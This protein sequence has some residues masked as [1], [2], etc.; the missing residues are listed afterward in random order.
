M[1][2]KVW[3][4]IPGSGTVLGQSP[5]AS[6]HFIGLEIAGLHPKVWNIFETGSQDL[7]GLEGVG[8]HPRV[9]NSFRTQSQHP[10]AFQWTGGCKA[11][12]QGLEHLWERVPRPRWNGGCGAPS[13]GLEHFWDRVL[14]PKCISMDWRVWGSILGSGTVLGHSPNTPMLFNG[15]EGVGLHPE[16]WNILR[17]GPE[18][19]MHFNGLE[20]VGLH[21]RLWNS[22][23]IEY[24][25]PDAFQWTGRCKAPSQCS[26][27][28]WDSVM[29][30][31]CIS[32]DWRVLG[33][34]LGSGTVLEQSPETSMHFNLTGGCRTLSWSTEQFWHS[35]PM[36][37]YITMCMRV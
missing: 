19:Q 17:Q 27:H 11:P 18:T 15:L 21:P 3:R 14:K 6:M 10:K 30:P 25:D 16:V 4:S 2:W 34:I 8:L 31:Q 35:V 36:C 13:Q 37:Q 12:S 22:F 1:D 33:S 5:E 32:L 23:E 24:Q 28:F 7:N 9:W 26:E 29:R 20:G